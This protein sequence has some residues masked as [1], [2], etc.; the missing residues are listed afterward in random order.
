MVTYQPQMFTQ[1]HYG[2]YPYPKDVSPA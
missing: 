2:F 1:Q